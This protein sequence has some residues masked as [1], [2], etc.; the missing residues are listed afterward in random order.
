MGAESI[1]QADAVLLSRKNLLAHQQTLP[2]GN[3]PGKAAAR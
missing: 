2:A 3:P 1:E